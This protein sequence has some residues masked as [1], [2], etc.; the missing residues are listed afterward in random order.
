VNTRRSKIQFVHVRFLVMLLLIGSPTQ[1]YVNG[2]LEKK[3][4]G[5]VTISLEVVRG[6]IVS[7]PHGLA[8]GKGRGFPEGSPARPRWLVQQEALSGGV[9]FGLCLPE[10]FEDSQVSLLSANTKAN[11][12]RSSSSV[13][14]RVYSLKL[15]NPSEANSLNACGEGKMLQIVLE[16]ENKEVESLSKVPDMVELVTMII[17]PE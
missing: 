8:S 16:S 3:S 4:S 9:A 10:I 2:K 15:D 14:D 5:R 13:K 7:Q 1:A 6:A 12:G 11:G 17:K